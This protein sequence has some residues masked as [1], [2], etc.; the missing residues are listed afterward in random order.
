[1]MMVVAS[2]TPG[3]RVSMARPTLS[4]GGNAEARVFP[5][6]KKVL[7]VGFE[8]WSTLGTKKSV[9]RKYDSKKERR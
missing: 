4:V 7:P 1:M 6:L 9:K 3:W 8:S 2:L 5:L